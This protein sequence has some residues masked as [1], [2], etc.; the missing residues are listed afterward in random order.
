M[1]AAIPEVLRHPLLAR[2]GVVHGFG[3]RGSEAPAG[4]LRPR[5]VHGAEV[6]R[7]RVGARTEL[8]PAE[9]DAVVSRIPGAAIGVVTADCVPILACS[10]DGLAVAAIHAGWRGLARG[11][12][13]AGIEALAGLAGPGRKLVAVIGPHIGDC[14]YEVDGPVLA[15]LGDGFARE[16]AAASR[17]S[18]VVGRAYLD[19]G[20]LAAAAL[21][22]AGVAADAQGVL[23][24]SCTHCSVE[25]FHSYRRD[26]ERAGRMVHFVGVTE[27][28][29]GDR[30]RDGKA[31]RGKRP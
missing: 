21:E 16:L 27:Q 18:A 24:D 30:G 2:A 9:A 20:C 15:A 5:Q 8:S 29:A 4:T 3:V 14:C 12:V 19:L 22:R 26:G 28:G 6:A 23:P 25:R 7:I 10:E 17:P 31:A 1:S 11:V 13:E